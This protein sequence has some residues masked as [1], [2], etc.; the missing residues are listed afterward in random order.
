MRPFKRLLRL[1]S[2]LAIAVLALSALAFDRPLPAD[3]KSG[4]LSVTSYPNIEIDGKPRTLSGGARIWSPDNLT[5]VPNAL[6]SATYMA[7]YTE[8]MAGAID[9]IWLLTADEVAALPTP[10]RRFTL[11]R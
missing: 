6:G 8:D 7:A 3:A 4:K 1:L 9:R 2:G 11:I 5:V 10:P